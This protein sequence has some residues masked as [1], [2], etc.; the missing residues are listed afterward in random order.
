MRLT[1][2][3]RGQP[4]LGSYKEMELRVWQSYSG[5]DVK[6]QGHPELSARSSS[7][8]ISPPRSTWFPFAVKR[9]NAERYRLKSLIPKLQ[10]M[11]VPL[12][13]G[14]GSFFAALACKYRIYVTQRLRPKNRVVVA[15]QACVSW[16]LVISSPSQRLT[17]FHI[18]F[19]L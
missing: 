8:T 6:P 11:M 4:R 18:S 3:Q 9:M 19:L 12:N 16:R 17:C 15:L 2:C 5:A 14:G 7:L 1:Y 13:D 10:V